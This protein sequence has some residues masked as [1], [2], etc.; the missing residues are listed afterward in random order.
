MLSQREADHTSSTADGKED[1]VRV[2]STQL[3][4][5]PV[6]HLCT[7]SVNLEKGIWRNADFQAQEIFK[8]MRFPKQELVG[9]L[10]MA[11]TGHGAFLEVS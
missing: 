4:Y 2:H 5:N 1:G 7:S 10:M 6:Q 8:D 11:E 3:P 9:G